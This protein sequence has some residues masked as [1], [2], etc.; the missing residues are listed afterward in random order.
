MRALTPFAPLLPSAAAPGFRTYDTGSR[1]SRSERSTACRS[2]CAAC[3]ARPRGSGPYESRG[4]CCLRR[5]RVRPLY[6]GVL[7]HR[8]SARS[9]RGSRRA[10]EPT[11]PDASEAASEARP[12]V[13]AF[14]RSGLV[15]GERIRA[16]RPPA[17]TGIHRVVKALHPNAHAGPTPLAGPAFR[18]TVED[19]PKRPTESEPYAEPDRARRARWLRMDGWWNDVRIGRRLAFPQRRG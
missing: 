9:E 19:P 2:S 1:A 16:E 13:R 11:R 3:D 5:L 7:Q 15:A 4:G 14:E 8:A 18:D 12:V 17:Q 10:G 6:P